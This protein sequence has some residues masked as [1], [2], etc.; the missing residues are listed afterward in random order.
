VSEQSESSVPGREQRG[1]V[2][3]WLVSVRVSQEPID[4]LAFGSGMGPHP[5]E[6]KIIA[7]AGSVIL[8][9]SAD[10]WQSGTLNYSPEPRLAVTA[11]FTPGSLAARSRDTS[12][13]HASDTASSAASAS[14]R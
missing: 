12:S 10:L 11:G 4:V 5:D 8:F 2:Q 13:A 1:R 6:V 7:P 9:N 3:G 14:N